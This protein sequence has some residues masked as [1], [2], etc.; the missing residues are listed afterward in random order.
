[1]QNVDDAIAVFE[2][3]KPRKPASITATA[4]AI[5]SY[6]TCVAIRTAV[7]SGRVILNITKY[8]TTTSKLQNAL[9]R[10]YPSAILV[11]RMSKGCTATELRDEAAHDEMVKSHLAHQTEK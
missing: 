1:M 5:Y 10:E 6:D 8:S 4:E 2:G 11:E 7:D 3:L 9:R